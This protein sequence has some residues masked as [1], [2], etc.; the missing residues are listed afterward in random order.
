MSG[1]RGFVLDGIA[2]L[3]RRYDYEVKWRGFPVRGFDEFLAFAVR[4][5]VAPRTV[6]DVGVGPGTPWLYAAFPGSKLVLIEALERFRPN[7]EALAARHDADFLINAL[8]AEAGRLTMRVP[9]MAATGA[10]L[11]SREPEFAKLEVESSRDISDDICEVDVVTL[12]SVSHRWPGPYVL[13]L[14]V[15]G[16]ELDVLRGATRTLADTDLIIM[17]MSVLP[18]YEG[19]CS[20]AD[21]LGFLDRAGFRLF[22]IPEMS[23]TSRNGPLSTIDAAFV[24]KDNKLRLPGW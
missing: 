5:G 24:R 15:E 22:D 17:E 2:T 7:V 14:D 11:R 21:R 23:Q 3:L 19:E 12:D 9:K 8:G 16:A 6:F 13:K 4:C 10:S 1:I 18:R 20:F